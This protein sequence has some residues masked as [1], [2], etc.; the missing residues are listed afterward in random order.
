MTSALH[1]IH[2]GNCGIRG[3]PI[4]DITSDAVGNTVNRILIT[5]TVNSE[6]WLGENAEP[7]F[8]LQV[9]DSIR[10]VNGHDVV[11]HLPPMDVNYH[12]IATE[13][14]SPSSVSTFFCL[15]SDIVGEQNV[16]FQ[17]LF[18]SALLR[19]E[20]STPPLPVPLQAN[21][22]VFSAV[23]ALWKTAFSCLFPIKCYCDTLNITRYS[24]Y[25]SRR[26][27]DI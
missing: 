2:G 8:F 23:E 24:W 12:H 3:A 16:A 21:R 11:P 19:T 1:K 9:P 25:I 13:A 26:L 5:H 14:S 18:A 4:L 20:F 10:V 22:I 27:A 6:N 15:P 7:F 17:D